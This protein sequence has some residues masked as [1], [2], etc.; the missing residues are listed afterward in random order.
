MSLE[1]R[2]FCHTK[3]FI[4]SSLRCAAPLHAFLLVHR[5]VGLFEQIFEAGH[6]LGFESRNTDTESEFMTAFRP[7]RCRL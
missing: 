2:A 7:W 6:A 5:L 3:L 1:F 4:L